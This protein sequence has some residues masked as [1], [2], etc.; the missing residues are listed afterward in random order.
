MNTSRFSPDDPKLT[1]YAL[2]E[3]D[4]AEASEIAAAIQGDAAAQA[5]VDEIRA[6]AGQ[7]EDALENEPVLAAESTPTVAEPT[8]PSKIVRFPFYWA[9][10]LAAACLLV[11]LASHRQSGQGTLAS[12]E[13]KKSGAVSPATERPALPVADMRKR[14]LAPA[15][16]DVAPAPLREDGLQVGRTVA[17]NEHSDGN[18]V[19]NTVQSA[20]RKAEAVG[21]AAPHDSTYGGVALQTTG[22]LRPPQDYSPSLDYGTRRSVSDAPALVYNR[23]SRTYQPGQGFLGVQG[24]PLESRGDGADLELCQLT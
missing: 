21:P 4:A 2:G 5:V 12:A 8:S 10:G 15:G 1:A 24:F 16:S 14:A 19:S 13:G 6:L 18:Q 23:E 11:V 7:L 22:S 3:L 20:I 9:S 17:S